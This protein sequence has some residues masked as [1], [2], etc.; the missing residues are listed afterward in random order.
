MTDKIRAHIEVLFR[1]APATRRVA[2]AR[3][4]L[5]AGCLDKYADL[6]AAGRTPEEAYIAVISGIGDVDELLNAIER[7]E[8]EKTPGKEGNQRRKRALFI[9]AGVFLYILSVAVVPFVEF[10]VR[11]EYAGGVFLLMVGLATFVVVYGVIST[12]V[13]VDRPPVSMSGE[14]QNQLNDNR[15]NGLLG[16]V[17]SSMWS[18]LVMIYLFAGFVFQW[19]HPGWLIFLFGAVLQIVIKIVLGKK[20]AGRG[21]MYAL[22]WI[23]S[24]IVFLVISFLTR[25]WEITWMIFPLTLC[26]Q[27]MMRLARI[28][29]KS[30][31]T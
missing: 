30:D 31:E 3:E 7:F 29:R 10:N 27:Q 9:A 22:I 2:E 12:R 24:V 19:W 25:R 5:L 20:G 18:L 4:E 23:A 1:N 28:W 21:D 17:T 14:I 6:T 8:T 13:K 11:A 26:I 15:R 16:A